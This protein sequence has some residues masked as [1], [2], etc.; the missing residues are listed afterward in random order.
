MK[1]SKLEQLQERF[2]EANTNNQVTDVIFS[3]AFIKVF[4]GL[5]KNKDDY[6]KQ[7]PYLKILSKIM[8]I[9]P[10]LEVFLLEP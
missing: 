7:K 2:V 6:E 1:K 3:E 8:R 10:E 4:D 9:H 5:S